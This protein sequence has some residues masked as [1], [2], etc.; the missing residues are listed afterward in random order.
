MRC[1]A[2]FE[3]CGGRGSWSLRHCRRC[4]PTKHHDARF[5]AS[6]T[7]PA[8]GRPKER[9]YPPMEPK[10]KARGRQTGRAGG[11]GPA[12][13][14]CA[15]P[16]RRRNPRQRYHVFISSE[17]N[18]PFASL[19]SIILIIRMTPANTSRKLSVSCVC[20]V[21]ARRYCR[22]AGLSLSGVGSCQ[23]RVRLVVRAESNN[24]TGGAAVR[25][26]G[27]EDG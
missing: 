23:V 8:T 25:F 27:G 10:R 9:G 6:G 5:A 26:C 11:W 14:S 24:K 19:L 7:A 3:V 12:E 13:P 2:A 1:S 16:K 17:T 22:W 15:D 4:H 20:G 18:C 21:S